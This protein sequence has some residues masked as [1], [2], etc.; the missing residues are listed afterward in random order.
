MGSGSPSNH[1]LA[2]CKCIWASSRGNLSLWCTFPSLIV[3]GLWCARRVLSRLAE[4]YG[5]LYQSGSAW[6]Q[7]YFKMTQDYFSWRQALSGLLSSTFLRPE[8]SNMSRPQRTASYLAWLCVETCCG[9]GPWGQ[10]ARLALGT[11]FGRLST[12]QPLL[13]SSSLVSSLE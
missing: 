10:G 3:F 5:G 9:M 4:L 13:L 12:T 2:A 6:R 1:T 11:I 7:K 8:H